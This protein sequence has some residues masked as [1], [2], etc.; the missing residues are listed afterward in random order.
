MLK[1]I[2]VNRSSNSIIKIYTIDSSA[3][4]AALSAPFVLVH[5]DS[6]LNRAES[7]FLFAIFQE[8]ASL[9]VNFLFDAP[10]LTFLSDFLCLALKKPEESLQRIFLLSE[11]PESSPFNQI[12]IRRRVPKKSVSEVL[13][14]L[15]LLLNIDLHLLIFKAKASEKLCELLNFFSYYKQTAMVVPAS[16]FFTEHSGN[17]FALKEG[18]TPV[19]SPSDIIDFIHQLNEM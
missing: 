4:E 13:E 6:S 18:A 10:A 2:S 17:V 14:S 15:V 5:V 16:P 12:S 1:I 11:H 7:E 9:K 3:L 19:T 8:T